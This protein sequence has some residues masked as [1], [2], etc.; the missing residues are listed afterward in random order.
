M[1]QRRG[2]KM[3]PQQLPQVAMLHSEEEEEEEVLRTS[4]SLTEMLES[5][6]YPL[7]GRLQGLFHHVT[8]PAA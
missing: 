2:N 3:F 6:D 8:R 7:R 1:A 5:S 4:A